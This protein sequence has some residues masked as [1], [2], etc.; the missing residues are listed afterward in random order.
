MRVVIELR[1]GEMSEILLNQLYTQTA[2]Q[3]VFGIDMV[4]LHDERPRT[5]NL[6]EI[7]EVDFNSNL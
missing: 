6:K 1:R 2:M 4:A 7:L 5:L 3:S